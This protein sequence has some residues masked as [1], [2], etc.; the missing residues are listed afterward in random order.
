MKED[1]FK[2]LLQAKLILNAHEIMDKKNCQGIV[3][4]STLKSK[5]D[6]KIL[7]IHKKISKYPIFYPIIAGWDKIADEIPEELR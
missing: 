3:L 2:P 7:N 5:I 6:M 4:G 1:F